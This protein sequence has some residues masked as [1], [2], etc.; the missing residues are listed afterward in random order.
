[1]SEEPVIEN[2]PIV[3]VDCDQC[4]AMMSYS[5]THQALHCGHCENTK[6]LPKESDLVIEQ[7]IA[8]A[9]KLSSESKGFGVE[10]TSFKCT[11]CGAETA[12]P[13]DQPTL[14]CPFCNS[15]NVNKNAHAQQVISPSGLMPF[16]IDKSNA[17]SKFKQWLSKGF[18]TPSDLKKVARLNKINGVYLP[19]WTYDAQT[20]SRWTAE[21]GYY[22]YVTET[23]RDSDGNTKTRQV[24]KTRWVPSSGYYA[25]F[26]DDVLVIGSNGVTQRMIDKIYPYDLKEVVNF[27]GKYMLG[28][29]S[30]VYQKDVEQGFGVA[31][32]IMDDH[33]RSACSRQVPGDTHR[34][35]NVRTRKSG[36]TFKHIL[37]PVWVAAYKYKEKVRQFVVNGQTGKVAGKKPVS[38]GKVILTIVIAL[39]VIGAIIGL[40][41]AFS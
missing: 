6:P 7:S 22:Y 35:L 29:Q 5:P 18:F 27:E 40:I 30:E 8:E 14:E 12:V 32:K 21:S 10:M 3:S 23:Y 37:L 20:D 28:M 2:H 36:V 9:L 25:H 16:K 41:A 34:N 15:P 31:E 26:F 24:R 39:A 1:M 11:N 19:F 33:I 17:L 13:G 4:G 38:T